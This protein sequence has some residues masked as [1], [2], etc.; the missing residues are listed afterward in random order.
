MKIDIPEG[1]EIDR[2]T[3]KEINKLPKTWEDL[4]NAKGYYVEKY[5]DIY[6][7]ENVFLTEEQAEAS[8]ALA[9]LSQLR[10][11]YRNGWIPDYT[12]GSEKYSVVFYSSLLSFQD[13]ET[14]DLF[15][16]NF[17]DLIEKAKLLLS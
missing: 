1:Y 6:N 16:K 13:E 4:V 3:F 8:V 17:R 9:Q 15:L 10:D 14:R 7:K 2:V 5:S 11:L 12:Y